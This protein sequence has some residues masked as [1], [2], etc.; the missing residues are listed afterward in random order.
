[1]HLACLA[2]R[3]KRSEGASDHEAQLTAVAA[4]QS[5]SPLPWKEDER[6]F[7]DKLSNTPWVVAGLKAKQQEGK[8]RR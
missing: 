3:A 1:V 6:A 8:K 7:I 2:Y 5:V 4:V